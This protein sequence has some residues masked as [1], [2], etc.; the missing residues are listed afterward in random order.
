M[1]ASGD[2][3]PGAS[4]ERN[5]ARGR[6]SYYELR[7]LCSGTRWLPWCGDGATVGPS[8]P[9]RS[10]RRVACSVQRLWSLGDGQ[11]FPLSK[12]LIRIQPRQFQ[13][14]GL[15]FSNPRSDSVRD[16]LHRARD[17]RTRARR[18]FDW[19]R[20]FPKRDLRLQRP[21]YAL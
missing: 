1:T 13:M 18:R 8:F 21:P 4:R 17:R 7:R 19:S 2:C 5:S 14:A 11:D 6:R 12:G 3:E 15:A 20:C 16:E 10:S 9:A